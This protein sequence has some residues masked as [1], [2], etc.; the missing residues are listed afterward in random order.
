MTVKVLLHSWYEM[1]A[2][3]YKKGN[4][5]NVGGLPCDRLDRDL[6]NEVWFTGLLTSPILDR[7]TATA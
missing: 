1:A 4:W 6:A 5:H 3:A 7:V 2:S